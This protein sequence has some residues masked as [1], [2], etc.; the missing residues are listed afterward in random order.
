VNGAQCYNA[1]MSG[2]NNVASIGLTFGWIGPQSPVGTI[3]FFSGTGGTTPA[4]T[5]GDEKTYATFYAQ[6]Y[7]VVQVEWDFP[8]EEYSNGTGGSFLDGACRPATFLSYINGTSAYH[9]SG[10]PMCAQGTSAG[11]AQIAY[12]LAWYGAGSYLTY[13]ELLNGPVLSQIDTGCA[14]YPVELD[15][16][17]CATSNGTKQYG[18]TA[19][20]NSWT[21]SP[22]YVPN[23][24]ASIDT[25]SGTPANSCAGPNSYAYLSTWKPMGIVDGSN[26]TTS[27]TFSYPT[28]I[29]AWLCANY[30][31]VNGVY[32]CAPPSCPNNS[33]SQGNFFYKQFTSSGNKN[34]QL[35]GVNACN[36]EEGVS[37]G[38]DPDTGNP[39][40]GV[41]EADMTTNCVSN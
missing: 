12:S 37:D 15:E 23:F 13:A 3:V 34:F 5:G 22:T 7:E 29:H 32:E 6:T 36:Q 14:S 19:K 11:S 38:T 1:T 40:L 21:D 4:T 35:T 41:I 17:I 27:P 26:G 39:A 9:V 33:A 8:W 2:C 28:G 20:T 18:C 30:A 16:T 10:S 24:N 31:T 25:W